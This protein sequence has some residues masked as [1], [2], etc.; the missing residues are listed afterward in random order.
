MPVSAHPFGGSWGYQPLGLYAP[1]PP[2]GT[3]RQLQRF[4][5]RCHAAGLLVNTWTCDDPARMRE[6]IEW[7]IDGICTNV[8]DI[9]RAVIAEST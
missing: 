9:A 7:G 2:L 3:P 4:V 1:H 5:D 6:L 8:P